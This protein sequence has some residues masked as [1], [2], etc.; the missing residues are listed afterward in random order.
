MKRNLTGCLVSREIGT[1]IQMVILAKKFEILAEHCWKLYHTVLWIFLRV[2]NSFMDNQKIF[3]S[4]LKKYNILLRKEYHK[5]QLSFRI[6]QFFLDTS[7][8]ARNT[9]N[10]VSK[11][12]AP[13]LFRTKIKTN[14]LKT[15]KLEIHLNEFIGTAKNSKWLKFF[16]II[17]VQRYNWTRN[18][19]VTLSQKISSVAHLLGQEENGNIR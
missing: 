14:F 17:N 4:N 8:H 1:A 7:F 9:N 16:A 18:I 10:F 6:D 11:I 2:R 13:S 15:E 19:L 12:T 5:L 3:G